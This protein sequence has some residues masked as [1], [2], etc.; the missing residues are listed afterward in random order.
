LV[1]R[2]HTRIAE[3]VEEEVVEKS[4]VEES[5]ESV[6]EESEESVVEESEE[7]VVEES[8]ESVVGESEVSV[9]GESVARKDVPSLYEVGTYNVDNPMSHCLPSLSKRGSA[10]VGG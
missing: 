7:S 9:V 3:D 2:T 4:V 6:V 8:E 5:E 10:I 1:T